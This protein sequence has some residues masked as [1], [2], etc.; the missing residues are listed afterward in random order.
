MAG[1][2]PTHKLVVKPEG[3]ERWTEIGA[4]WKK[5]SGNFSVVLDI[6]DTGQRINALLVPNT[7]KPKAKPAPNDQPAA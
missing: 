7:P 6:E 2:P 1:T 4:A 3:A 5:A